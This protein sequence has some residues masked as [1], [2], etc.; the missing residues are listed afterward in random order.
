MKFLSGSLFSCIPGALVTAVLAG[1]AA[2]GAL[3][4]APDNQPAYGVTYIEVTPSAEATAAGL[5]RQV[6]A[7]SRKEAGNLRYDILQDIERRN[8]FAILETW[9]DMKAIEAHAAGAGMKQLREKLEPLRTGFLDERLDT[10]I[11]VGPVP[12]SVGKGAIYVV[13]HVDVTGP[14]KDDAIVMMKKLAAES[15]REAGAA[16]FDVWQQ[17]NRLNHFTVTELWKDQA[18]LDAHGTAAAPRA[19]REQIGHMLGALYDDRRYSNLE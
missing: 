6:A 12:P 16:R 15:R 17:A 9:S 1:V 13:T 3:A 19:F 2:P 7:A 8:Q 4:Q 10:G 5:L 11:D 14:F 18:A